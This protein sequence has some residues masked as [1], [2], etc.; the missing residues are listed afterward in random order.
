MS[1]APQ[2]SVPMIAP[3]ILVVLTSL[4]RAE[5]GG[6]PQ[7]PE[8]A[9]L[10][11]TSKIFRLNVSPNGYPP[12]IV[13]SD[14][15]NY[16]GIVWDT[17]SEIGERLGYQVVPHRI[18]RKRVDQMLLDGYID[19]TPRAIEWTAEPEKFLF[20]QPITRIREVLFTTTES[21]VEFEDPGNLEGVTVVTHLGYHYPALEPLFETGKATRF[22]VTKDQD[23]LRFLLDGSQ[24]D[25][26]VADE[27][28]GRWIAQENGWTDRIRASESAISDYGYRLMLRE[29]WSGFAD[30]F[31]RELNRMKSSGELDRIHSRYR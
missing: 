20:T 12:Y 26:A 17:V 18:P 25:V 19:G 16:S 10:A 2:N 4:A 29:N 11:E 7:G 1:S 5:E 6:T 14:S 9:D 23:L 22:D 21:D 3:L 31:N 15:G 28:V 13:P 24:F 27:S 30:A 8:L